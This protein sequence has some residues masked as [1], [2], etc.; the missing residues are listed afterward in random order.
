MKSHIPNTQLQQFSVHHQ[1]C[2]VGTSYPAFSVLFESKPHF[3]SVLICISA[4]YPCR[5]PLWFEINKAS[6]NQPSLYRHWTRQELSGR[7]NHWKFQGLGQGL[8]ESKCCF[9]VDRKNSV[10]QIGLCKFEKSLISNTAYF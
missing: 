3:I 7:R 8:R 6:Y 10:P 1:L 2:F 5:F 9:C 4:C